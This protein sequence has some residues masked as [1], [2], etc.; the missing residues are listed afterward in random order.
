MLAVGL[1]ASTTAVKAI[2]WD[3]AGT[4]VAEGRAELTLENPEVDAWE[5]DA[6]S[7][8]TA[9]LSALSALT[10][11]LGPRSKD[12]IALCVTHQRETFVLCDDAGQPL[13]P[14]LSWMDA[15]GRDQ[16]ERAVA[17]LGRERL[18]ELSGKP[19]CITP[20]FY[21]L[22]G[23]LARQPELARNSLRF[24]DVHA[25][26]VFRLTG[27]WATSLASADPLGI[28]DMRERAW[29]EELVA[30]SGLDPARLPQLARP[31][32]IL[33]RLSASV[34]HSTGLPADVALVAG[35]GDGQAAGL[36]A[37]ITE[38]GRAYLNLGTAVVSGVL[39]HEY[40]VDLAF[41][42]LFAADGEAFFLESDLKGG[43]FTLNWLAEKWCG[44]KTASEVTRVLGDLEREAATLPAG[45]AGLVLVPYWN[46][47][48]NPYWDDDATGIIVG[49]TGSHGPAHMYRAILEGIAFEERLHVDGIERASNHAIEEMVV[50]GGG[51]RSDLFCQILADVLDRPIRRARS[52]EATALGAGILAAVAAN[53][54]P[55]LPSAVQAMTGTDTSFLP[56]PDAPRYRELQREVYAPL[57]P[58]LAGPLERLSRITRGS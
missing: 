1:D 12:I 57:Y 40:V 38:P 5:Q 31:G 45:A 13:A 28:V 50:M 17:E 30:F 44:A 26:L 2:A 9:T 7:W 19:A 49:F 39:S 8:W 3:A 18:H 6:E 58:A 22:L 11:Q 35:A 27:T 16:V 23:L 53:M 32:E 24:L 47:V 55:D 33:G 10:G 4:R 56:G 51:S 48:M 37:G 52:S 20:S 41:R 25:F 29:A 36:G 42:T 21:K 15:R 43:T 54:Q 34:A 46:G 14:A